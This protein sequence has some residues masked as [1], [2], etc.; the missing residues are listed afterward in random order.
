M[1]TFEKEGLEVIYK[2]PEDYTPKT[3]AQAYPDRKD[4]QKGSFG[5]L[6]IYKQFF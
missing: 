3:S 2:P 1:P 4:Q 5:G 6:K